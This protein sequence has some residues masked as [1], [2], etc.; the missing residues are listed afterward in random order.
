MWLLLLLLPTRRRWHLS[1]LLLLLPAPVIMYRLL[2]AMNQE[3]RYMCSV[4]HMHN[5]FAMDQWC[6]TMSYRRIQLADAHAVQPQP[7]D[8][9]HI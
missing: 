8:A 6:A 1:W 5:I 7:G 9:L 4:C 2:F 3:M